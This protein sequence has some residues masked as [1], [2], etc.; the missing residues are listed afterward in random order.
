MGTLLEHWQAL[1]SAAAILVGVVL[2]A[3]V[4]HYVVFVLAK[5]VSRRTG[6]IIQD[7]LVRHG[8]RPTRWIFPLLAL[9][10]VLPML[11]FRSDV[12]R[13]LQHAVGLGLILSMGWVFILLADVYKCIRAGCGA[14]SINE[15]CGCSEGVGPAVL[16]A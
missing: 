9:V 3:L 15:R 14:A 11:P 12:L 16:R 7:S 1:L 13:A 8:E 10:L 2:V 5:R 4:G 6:S